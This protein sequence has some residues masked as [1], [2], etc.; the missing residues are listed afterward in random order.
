VSAQ[1]GQIF[2]T[3]AGSR[4]IRYYEANG[5]R[6][7]KHG[8]RTKS[9]AHT[10]LDDALRRVRLGP[11]HRPNATLH[12]LAAA[13]LGQRKATPSTLVWLRENLRSALEAFG[14]QPIGA[15]RAD[16]IGA[17]P[18]SLAEGKRYRSHRGLRQVLQAAVRWKWVGEPGGAGPE[19]RAAIERDP[20]VRLVGGGRCGRCRAR[21]AAAPPQPSNTALTI[22][23][24]T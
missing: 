15:L 12:E 11:L 19:R 22:N 5:R 9:E 20:P 2:R 4:A 6:R 7:Q 14:D 3:P 21:P 18:A 10:A 8:F 1:R 24:L 13:Y 23:F 16:Q 17:W